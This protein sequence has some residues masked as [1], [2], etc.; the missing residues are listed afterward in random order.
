MAKQIEKDRLNDV[1]K[2]EMENLFSREKVTIKSGEDLPCGAVI[3]KIK[4]T[5]PTTGTP[6]GG[7]T[8]D[9]TCTGVTAGDQVK[10]GSYTLTC[11][12]EGANAGTFEVKDPDDITLGQATVGVAYDSEEINFTLNDGSEDFDIGDIF[13]IAV[14]AGTLKVVRIDFDAV[15]GSEDAYGF[16]IAEYDASEADVEGVAIL[17]DAI[18]DPDHLAW[19]ME[20]TS[21][22][23]DVPAVGDTLVG[24]GSS[25]TGEI[26]KITLS[27]GSWSGGDAAGTLWLRKVS[28]EFQ[29][30]NLD[31]DDRS[32]SNFATIAAALDTTTAL[33]AMK[34]AGIIQREG[35]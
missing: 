32:I 22:G 13:T 26:C 18:I 20:F 9:G 1:L 15:D 14:S 23:T 24:A 7:N 5:C 8:G 28:G 30:E 27:S 3:G 16:V 6:D 35:A 17:R 21:G 10:P 25:D 12:A 4:T 34:A 11:I 2:W 19:P 31:I 33:A 29:A